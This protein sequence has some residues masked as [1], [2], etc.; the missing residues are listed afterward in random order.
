[1]RVLRTTRAEGL[2]LRAIFRKAYGLP[3]EGRHIGG[4]PHNDPPVGT[5][6]IVSLLDVDGDTSQVD[7]LL[8]EGDGAELDVDFR[9]SGRLTLAERIK[10]RAF[11]RNLVTRV[12]T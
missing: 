11:L 3:I 8:G 2:V 5:E 7:V 6:D 1:M 4:G 9:E 10:V 12:V